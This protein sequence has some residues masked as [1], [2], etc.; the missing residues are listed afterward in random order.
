MSD[1][2]KAEEDPSA[3]TVMFQKFVEDGSGG[4]S[5]RS[6]PPLALVVGGILVVAFLVVVVVLAFT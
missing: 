6:I 3:S 4:P 5:R 1:M 2:N